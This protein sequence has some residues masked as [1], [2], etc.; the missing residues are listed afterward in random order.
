MAL[1][2]ACLVL[3]VASWE[4]RFGHCVMKDT[5]RMIQS[6]LVGQFYVLVRT[7]ENALCGSHEMLNKSMV[8]IC[9]Q[10]RMFCNYALSNPLCDQ[11]C[12]EW[13]HMQP[14]MGSRKIG[15][16]DLWPRVRHLSEHEWIQAHD[17]IQSAPYDVALGEPVPTLRRTSQYCCIIW[18]LLC[19]PLFLKHCTNEICKKK[20]SFTVALMASICLEKPSSIF[21][22]PKYN[23]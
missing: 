20:S 23:E 17:H 7:S 14:S 10:V 11:Q 2:P 9:D 22:K 19:F 15:V 3:C 1:C 21:P 16:C 6:E 4:H 13:T 8:W 18:P 12:V 5:G